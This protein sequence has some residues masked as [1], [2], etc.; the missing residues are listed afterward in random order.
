MEN[1][2][3]FLSRLT[4]S[5]K[6]YNNYNKLTSSLSFSGSTFQ[7]IQN[8]IFYLLLSSSIISVH[9][10]IQVEM[11]FLFLW[12]KNYTQYSCTIIPCV[13]PYTTLN[14][15]IGHKPHNNFPLFIVLNLM[16]LPTC[17]IK[18]NGLKAGFNQIKKGI[19]HSHPSNER[20]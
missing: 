19:S 15:L 6:G 13:L 16:Q 5:Y 18:K 11:F 20:F 14:H 4:R 7:Y 12:L 2:R 17:E 8:I 1:N 9:L 3:H 10:L